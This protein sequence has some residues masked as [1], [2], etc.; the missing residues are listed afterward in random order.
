MVAG[1]TDGTGIAASFNLPIGI[2]TDGVNL[3]VADYLNNKIRKIVIATGVVTTLAG[4]GTAGV[5]DGTGVTATFSNP[6]GI[7]T[8]GVNLYA[9][10]S[11]NNKIRKIVIATGVVTTFAGSGAVGAS[12]GTGIA[13]TFN[14]PCGIT[15]DGANLYVVDQT[16]HKIRKIQ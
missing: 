12:D 8:D 6:W 13:A 1:A 4:S 16:N 10:D 11:W 5:A 14:L 3:Y 2:T 9:A 15:T 7:T